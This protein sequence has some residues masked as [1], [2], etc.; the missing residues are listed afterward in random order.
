MRLARTLAVA[1]LLSGLA[2]AEAAEPWLDVLEDDGIRVSQR[3]GPGRALPEFRAVAEIAA[4]RWQVLAVIVDIPNQPKWMHRL[5]EARVIRTKAQTGS[6]LGAVF[7]LRMDLP[8]PVSDRDVVLESDTDFPD[9]G[10]SVTRFARAS[11]AEHEPIEGVIRMP[12]LRG[13]YAL[14]ALAPDRTRVE[15]Q[16]DADPG[17]SLPSWLVT[18]VSR[19]D[20][21]YTLK[22][23]RA[24]VAAAHAEYAEFVRQWDP[25]RDPR[26]NPR[27]DP[28][29][30]PRGAAGP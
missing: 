1:A 21:W 5:S 8:W 12:R 24:R 15:Y 28:R 9:E 13:H 16:V 11:H 22:D 20:P 2:S 18:R 3:V 26:R 7:Y 14:T 29:R 23:L 17:G 25:R 27:R 30:D 6:P 4:S 19:D 10:R